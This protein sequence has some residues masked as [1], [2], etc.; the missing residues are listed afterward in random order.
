MKKVLV[1]LSLLVILVS[2]ANSFDGKRKGFVLGGGLGFA[3]TAKWEVD[4]FSVVNETKAGIGINIL[5]GYAWDEKN[6]IVYEANGVGYNS[7]LVDVAITQGFTGASWYHYFNEPGKTMFITG[8]LGLYFFE[9]E[10][11]DANDYGGALM[12][13]GGYEFAPHW[14]VGLYFSAGKTSDPIF[15]YNHNHLNL[16]ISGIAF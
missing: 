6:M 7:D 10:H 16:L 14:Q 13:G 8:G 4:G 15:D 3:P 1:A 2:S 5:I 12:F 11:Y 9:A